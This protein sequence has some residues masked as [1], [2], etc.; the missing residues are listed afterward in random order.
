[1]NRCEVIVLY[2]VLLDSRVVSALGYSPPVRPW[3]SRKQLVPPVFLPLSA[4]KGRDSLNVSSREVRFSFTVCPEQ[5]ALASRPKA[6]LLGFL[7][8]SAHQA[9]E[10]TS[11][12]WARQSSGIRRNHP[13]CVPTGPTRLSTTPLT[14]F[15]NL[16][17]TT[18]P[19]AIQPFSGWWR[20]WGCVLQGF[21]PFTKT[22]Q[23][24][25]AGIPS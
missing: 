17:A 18:S 12:H 22:R 19:V 3:Y 25:T 2:R 8:P 20:S 11:W 23:F 7:A 10:L 13:T 9:T 6:T 24:V 5:P 21:I 15:L 16:S 1:L 14:G 4:F